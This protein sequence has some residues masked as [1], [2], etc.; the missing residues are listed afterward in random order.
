MTKGGK[1]ERRHLLFFQF[2]FMYMS[3]FIALELNFSLDLGS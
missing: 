3:I 2:S 1:K